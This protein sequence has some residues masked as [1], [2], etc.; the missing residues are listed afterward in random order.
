MRFATKMASAATVP[1]PKS[2]PFGPFYTITTHL[3]RGH[4]S[5]PTPQHKSETPTPADITVRNFLYNLCTVRYVTSKLSVNQS[6]TW[7]DND[8]ILSDHHTSQQR[9]PAPQ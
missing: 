6:L 7:G 1:S 3:V 4:H 9:A 5:T 8:E 2:P